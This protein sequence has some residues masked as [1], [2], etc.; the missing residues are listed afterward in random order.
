MTPGQNIYYDLKS[1]SYNVGHYF[2]LWEILVL[3][4]VTL[5]HIIMTG[6]HST[7]GVDFLLHCYYYKIIKC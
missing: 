2:T 5:R 7:I 6:S 4:K 3:H 1:K